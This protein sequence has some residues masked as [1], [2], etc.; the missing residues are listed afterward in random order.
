M[1]TATNYR[2]ALIALGVTMSLSTG[3]TSAMPIETGQKIQPPAPTMSAPL[4]FKRHNFQAFC[5][6]AIGCH[7]TYNS[8]QFLP[9]FG[10]ANPDSYVSPPPSSPEYRDKWP[11][12]GH[13]SILN[14]PG[15]AQVSWKSMDGEAHQASI[16]LSSIFEAGV[17]WHNVPKNDMADFFSGPYAGSPDIFLEVNDRTIN[18]YMT[19]FIPTKTEQVPGNS[20]SSFR[21][22]VLL[23]WTKTY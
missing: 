3:C 22:D 20:H 15:P 18:V 4:H 19:M 7:V 13:L 5:Y 6:N 9:L 14:F 2:S 21:N 12:R 8:H 23:V 16:D 1:P 10:E 11:G 17:V